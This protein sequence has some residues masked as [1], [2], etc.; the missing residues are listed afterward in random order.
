MMLEV[1]NLN[2]YYDNIRAL[3]CGLLGKT[4]VH[5]QGLFYPVLIPFF[6]R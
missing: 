2:V 5:P 3:T 6:I 4:S 1:T